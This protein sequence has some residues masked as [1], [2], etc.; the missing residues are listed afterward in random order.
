MKH[1]NL[2]RLL[3]G[4]LR[5]TP[6]VFYARLNKR[7]LISFLHPSFLLCLLFI[8]SPFVFFALSSL[9][10]GDVSPVTSI[11]AEYRG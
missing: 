5:G 3:P 2:K 10:S 6:E 8:V 9:M 11:A 4:M 1:L 7:S